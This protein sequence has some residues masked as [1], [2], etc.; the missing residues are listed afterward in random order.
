V[1]H[2]LNVVAVKIADEHSV[3]VGVV[4][5]PESRGVQDVR[6]DRNRRCVYPV[7]RAPIGRAEG[8]VR[9][10]PGG[11]GFGTEPKVRKP[12]R[13]RDADNRAVLARI[14]HRLLEAKIGEHS[15]IECRRG[16]D[17][18]GLQCN[19]IQHASERS[20]QQIVLPW[21]NQNNATDVGWTI[22]VGVQLE[23]AE[24]RSR[25]HAHHRR[26]DSA[27]SAYLSRRT[28]AGK[29]PVEDF[30]FVYY[31]HRPAQLRRWHPGAGIRLGGDAA[32][33]RAGWRYYRHDG[34]A[35]FVDIDAFLAAR[36]ITLAFVRELLTATSNRSAHF[37]CFG[38]HEWAMVYR[39]AP[40][41]ARHADWPLRLGV[42]G[43]D[44]VVESHQVKCSHVDAYRFFTPPAR[45]LN[46]LTPERETQVAMEQPGCLHAN[47]DLY[48]WAY[49]LSPAVSS[50][51]T[52]DCFDLA[53]EIRELDMRASPYDLTELGFDPIAIETPAGKAEYVAAQQVF[54]HRA[55]T[56]RTRLIDACD[57]I[58][59]AAETW[60]LTTPR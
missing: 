46:V 4:L 9:F 57:A 54:A 31:A 40:E 17:V 44:R 38:L 8:Y 11:P 50:D 36:S 26:I 60:F 30:L 48:K 28:Q 20:G 51:L 18:G 24:W 55:Q 45:S 25:E 39:L 33:E 6:A 22:V 7:D 42:A 10:T 3:V 16:V 49:K 12:V 23:E 21:T 32:R 2:S 53:R 41:Q 59:D 5:R 52:A 19:V 35:A 1:A 58:A 14:P 27:T 15:Q 47:M 13:S 43:T 37:G 56:L 29:H 34:A